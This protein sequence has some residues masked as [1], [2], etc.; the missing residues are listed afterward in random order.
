MGMAAI[1]SCDPDA[2][3]KLPFT[4]SIEDPYEIWL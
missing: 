3:N 1:W 2:A 4:L